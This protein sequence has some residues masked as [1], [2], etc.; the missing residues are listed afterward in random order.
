MNIFDPISVTDFLLKIFAAENNSSNASASNSNE[1]LSGH[2]QQLGERL[3]P[4]VFALHPANAQKI[5][6]MLLELPPTQL[7]IIL[8]SED[9]LRQ[10][11]D[12]AMDVIIYRQRQEIGALI[13]TIRFT[14]S[15]LVRRANLICSYLA[16]SI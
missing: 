15:K 2:L 5:T 8:A 4:K 6:G 12:E 10:K 7:L 13:S 9:T 16:S 14:Q 1:H 3:Y 11:A